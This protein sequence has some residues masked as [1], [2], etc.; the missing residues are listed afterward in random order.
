VRLAYGDRVI[1]NT[2]PLANWL[3]RMGEGLYAHETPD[4]YA[5][6]SSAWSGPGQMETRF[7]IAHAIGAGSAGLFKPRTAVCPNSRP[8]RKSRMYS[9]HSSRASGRRPQ[10]FSR[11][12]DHCRNG[13]ACICHH[14][15][16]FAAEEKHHAPPRSVE[17]RRTAGSLGNRRTRLRCSSRGIE[18]L[19]AQFS[20]II[21][22]SPGSIL[23]ATQKSKPIN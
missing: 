14:P 11:K 7:E 16:S 4:G 12:R 9:R 3:Q 10:A 8:F 5:L 18:P 2:D 13:T 20:V 23:G 21:S 19:P 6:Q 1:L 15:N 22:A 17:I